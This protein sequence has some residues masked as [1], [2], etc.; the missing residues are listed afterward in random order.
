[1]PHYL[2]QDDKIILF[3]ILAYQ[4][5][6]TYPVVHH[7]GLGYTTYHYSLREKQEGFAGTPRPF[8]EPFVRMCSFLCHASGL[9]SHV[10][11][12]LDPWAYACI[13]VCIQKWAIRSLDR[14]HVGIVIKPAPQART[15]LWNCSY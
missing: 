1:M 13:H 12:R 4:D 10:L 6:E 11:M 15:H 3:I 9:M 5:M 2:S 14:L 7:P 8:L